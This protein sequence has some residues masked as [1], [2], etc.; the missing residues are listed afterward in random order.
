MKIIQETEKNK[1]KEFWEYKE[2]VDSFLTKKTYPKIH[3]LDKLEKALLT[4]EK[5]IIDFRECSFKYQI[6]LKV[7]LNCKG[8]ELTTME[9]ICYGYFGLMGLIEKLNNFYLQT[10]DKKI[11]KILEIINTAITAIKYMDIIGAEIVKT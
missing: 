11:K 6:I 1:I 7:E 3:E 4:R 2:V 10:Q 9:Y 5:L 8:R